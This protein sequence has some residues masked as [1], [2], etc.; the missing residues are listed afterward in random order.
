MIKSNIPKRRPRVTTR[1]CIPM[2]VA[3]VPISYIQEYITTKE[4][5]IKN[6]DFPQVKHGR[7]ENR[8]KINPTNRN[9][10]I[11]T[12]N[13]QGDTKTKCLSWPINDK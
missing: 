4:K 13:G 3:S 1:V 6:I 12:S 2:R 7:K 11:E 10:S 8:D 9:S 5:C